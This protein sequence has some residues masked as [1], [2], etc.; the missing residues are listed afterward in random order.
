MTIKSGAPCA[1]A[2]LVCAGA[3]NAVVRN[4]GTAGNA[5]DF[6]CSVQITGPAGVGTG[7]V[8]GGGKF[9]ITA[10]HVIS[11]LDAGMYQIKH[12]GGMFNAMGMVA[13]HP[14]ADIA[15]IPLGMMLNDSYDLYMGNDID[16][17]QICFAGWGLSSAT[18]GGGMGE[19]PTGTKR[20]GYNILDFDMTD[21]ANINADEIGFDFDLAGGM[22]MGGLGNSEATTFGGDSGMGYLKQVGMSFQLVAVHGG[23][24]T[25]PG[26]N[27]DGSIS[28]GTRVLPY[29]DWIL[30][31]V[32][33]PGAL[34]LVGVGLFVAAR[35]RR[36]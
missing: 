8:I 21:N 5:G 13:V 22:G 6:K 1:L 35:R 31:N 2:V 11:N 26:L 12:D 33:S 19:L 7:T 28:Y 9:V 10:K 18:P 27:V 15:I 3:A 29:K 30:M 20:A 16:D 36:E 14:T 17:M 23:I 4:D 25:N 34:S 24:L 32:P